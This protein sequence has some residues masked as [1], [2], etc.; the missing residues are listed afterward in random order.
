MD[1]INALT[2]RDHRELPCPLA[3]PSEDT[4]RGWPSMNQEVGS[5]QTANVLVAL[6]L[7]FPTSGTVRNEFL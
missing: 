6:I 4:T 5:H 2:K 3:L 1:G 7:G